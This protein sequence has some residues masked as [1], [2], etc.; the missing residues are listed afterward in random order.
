[1]NAFALSSQQENKGVTLLLQERSRHVT[2]V[3][4]PAITKSWTI[5]KDAKLKYLKFLEVLIVTF[6]HS[7][8]VIFMV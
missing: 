6:M 2:E 1:M 7:Q 3:N 4:P 8:S 5:S